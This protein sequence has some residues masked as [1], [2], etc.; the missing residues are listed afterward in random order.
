MVLES[1]HG[2]FRR[3]QVARLN[4]EVSLAEKSSLT[5]RWAYDAV[6][7][8]LTELTLLGSPGFRSSACVTVLP[9]IAVE[10][11]YSVVR[12]GETQGRLLARNRGLPVFIVTSA[13]SP[14]KEPTQRAHPI[15]K[16]SDA[17]GACQIKLG[18]IRTS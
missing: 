1:R 7:V 14:Y 11:I 18:E 5:N 9:A 2:E 16:V 4:E 12:R 3:A 8:G 13:P 10:P 15:N 6:P 17:E